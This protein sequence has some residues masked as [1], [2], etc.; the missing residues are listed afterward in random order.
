[1]PDSTLSGLWERYGIVS[2]KDLKDMNAQ[3]DRMDESGD[4][5]VSFAEIM[6]LLSESRAAVEKS[7]AA[8]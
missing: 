5:A 2:E 1:M 4:G 3:F 8:A 6:D 7:I